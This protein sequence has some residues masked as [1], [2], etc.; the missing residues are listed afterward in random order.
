MIGYVYFLIL[1]ISLFVQYIRIS[2]PTNNAIEYKRFD[3]KGFLKNNNHNVQKITI[4][5]K[6]HNIVVI[7]ETFFFIILP[8]NISYLTI[9][10]RYISE[11]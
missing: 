7:C 1:L 4:F 5:I 3:I 6:K 9:L 8:N 10:K 11:E 2:Q